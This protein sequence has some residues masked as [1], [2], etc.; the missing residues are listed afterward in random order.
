M[1][2]LRM[3]NL[4]LRRV[5]LRIQRRFLIRSLKPLVDLDTQLATM[6]ADEKLGLHDLPRL[7]S[8]QR[9]FVA[10][11]V[12]GLSISAESREAG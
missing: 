2:R 7:T 8:Q 1:C 11:R 6:D 9:V 10:A 4:H 3:D 5:R 12:A